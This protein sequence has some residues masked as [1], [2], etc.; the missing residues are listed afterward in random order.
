MSLSVKAK[1]LLVATLP[2]IALSIIIII[3]ASNDMHNMMA[4][5]A[6]DIIEYTQNN[7]LTNTSTRQMQ[8]DFAEIASEAYSHYAVKAIPILLM[9]MTITVAVAVFSVRKIMTRVET[10]TAEITT[11]ALPST[12]LSYRLTES[13][14]D[15][16]TNLSVSLNKMM[17]EIEAMMAKIRQSSDSVSDTAKQVSGSVSAS[18]GVTANLNQNIDSVAS[19]VHELEASA[20]EITANV[21]S[22]SAEIQQVSTD[23]KNIS[24]DFQFMQNKTTELLTMIGSSSSGVTE[25]GVKI[26]KITAIL[27]SIQAIAEQTNLLALNAAIEAAR[28]G[29][30][31]RGFSVVA[32]EVRSLASRTQQSTEEIERMIKELKTLS[33]VTVGDMTRSEAEVNT[34][35][36]S[37][38]S[39]NNALTHLT[40]QFN[41]VA[42][43]ELQ[44]AAASEE[45]ITVIAAISQNN[46]EVRDLAAE[47]EEA[48]KHNDVHADELKR[49]SSELNKLVQNF[50][51]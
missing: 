17:A 38:S 46:H 42:D 8:A 21:Q 30:Q 50:K 20:S 9:L 33:D 31:G 43:R 15:E 19:A 28:A 16:L 40:E 12:P 10:I 1:L 14:N 13:G 49:I 47:T 18:Y 24:A 25:L 11:L 6:N 22:S 26:E 3:A 29:E 5:Q 32:D 23:S 7:D 41:N 44:I 35:A 34:M 2:G 39:S 37:I 45:Q 51:N 36:S 48:V 27:D 4:F